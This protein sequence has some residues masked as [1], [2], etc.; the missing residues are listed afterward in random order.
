MTRL[1]PWSALIV[2]VLLAPAL[3]AEDK[4]APPVKP[5]SP[6]AIDRSLTVSPQNAPVPA[7]KYRLLPLTWD[8]KEGNAV[9]IYLRL[10]HEQNDAAR[11]YWSETPKPWNAMPVD[12]VPLE[13]ARKFLQ[14]RRY[15]L[16]QLELGA[17]RR[18]ADWDYT[19]DEPDPIGLLLPDVQWMR[20]YAP[21]LILQ[22]RVALAEGD[23]ARAAHHLETGLAFSRHIAEGPTLIHGLVAIALV[24]QFA[25]TI[26]DF[27]ERPDAPN[28]YWALTALPHP[29]IDLRRAEEWEYQVMEQQFPELA[30]L[31]RERTAEQWDGVLRRVRTELQ[32]LA[33]LTWI[34]GERKMPPWFPKDSAPGDPA[35][36]SPDLPAARKFVARAR[37]LSVEQVEAMPPARV[38]LLFMVGT[39]H[40]DRDD[41]YRAIYLPYPQSSAVFEAAQKRLH[42]AP[43]SEGHVLARLFLPALP[44]VILAQARIDRIVAAL[45][46]IEALRMYAAAHDGKLPDKLADVTE[47]PLPDDPGTG[48]P[49]VYHRDG[50]T[51]TLVSEVPGG[52]LPGSGVRYRVTIR[53]K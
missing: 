52:P 14:E 6:W 44:K 39:F 10:V 25:G 12:K 24:Y 37:R 50:D 9:P 41:W 19:L 20:S 26:G 30:D 7:L 16:R 53:K 4:P 28:L 34:E 1:R 32:R 43:I 21:M 29:L 27:I 46:V 5:P 36:K 47:V 31:G 15:M 40:E 23:F 18:T 3:L 8:L 49:F 51:G 48:R 38:L 22:A 11:K 33:P 35:A 2:I 45:R 13:E 42:D 17:R